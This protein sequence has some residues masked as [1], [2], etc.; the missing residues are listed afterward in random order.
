MFQ[1]KIQKTKLEI[2]TSK[3]KV[4]ISVARA[5]STAT[6][7]FCWVAIVTVGAFLTPEAG[8]AFF[9]LAHKIRRNRV[10]GT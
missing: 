8:V 3:I 7:R 9:T 4:D 5:R 2:L 10:D 1:L 6:T